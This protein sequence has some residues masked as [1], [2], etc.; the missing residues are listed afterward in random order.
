MI[1]NLKISYI[2]DGD[3]DVTLAPVPGG[4]GLIEPY[5]LAAIFAQ[6]ARDS[7]I[8]ERKFLELLAYNLH[9][10]IEIKEEE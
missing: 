2:K 5:S 1:R 7:L 9:C 4:M 10:Q 3:L 6:V 8:N